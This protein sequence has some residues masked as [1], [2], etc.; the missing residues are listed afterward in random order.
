[1]LVLM[2]YVCIHFVQ[3]ISGR[4][5]SIFN[6]HSHMVSGDFIRL[7]EQYTNMASLWQLNLVYIRI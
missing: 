4:A 5:K 3:K 7:D 2:K 6:M 1:M